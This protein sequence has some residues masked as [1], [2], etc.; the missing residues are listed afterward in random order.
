M[1]WKDQRGY[2]VVYD[3]K[4]PLAQSNGNV[5]VHR[6]KWYD[7]HGPIPKGWIVHHK[8]GNKTNNRLSNLKA[9][10]PSDH[11]KEHNR[12][13]DLCPNPQGAV[14]VAY[15]RKHGVWNKGTTKFVR[16]K[17]GQCNAT[18]CRPLWK[19][20]FNKRRNM[21]IFCNRSCRSR[22]VRRETI[23]KFWIVRKVAAR[24]NGVRI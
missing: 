7:R 4:H 19:V 24:E 8:D 2:L 16:V 3:P 9:M 10:S 6:K 5:R 21:K 13:G 11:A 18:L 12:R 15:T 22:W 14:L 20:K 17:C 1:A 23:R